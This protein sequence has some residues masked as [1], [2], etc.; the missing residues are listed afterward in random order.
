LQ[1]V[2]F[3]TSMDS[4]GLIQRVARGCFCRRQLRNHTRNVALSFLDEAVELLRQVTNQVEA[5]FVQNITF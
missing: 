5:L 4:F 3:T 2:A 1:R